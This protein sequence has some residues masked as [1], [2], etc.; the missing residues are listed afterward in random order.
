MSRIP[1]IPKLEGYMFSGR[2]KDFP[3]W[4]DAATTLFAYLGLLPIFDIRLD[5][6]E[7]SN[8]DPDESKGFTN[9]S[10]GDKDAGTSLTPAEPARSPISTEH[11]QLIFTALCHH[12]DGC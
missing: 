11:R 8:T 9:D 12:P 5:D 7:A 10:D 3:S 6:D 4:L 1:A 2:Q